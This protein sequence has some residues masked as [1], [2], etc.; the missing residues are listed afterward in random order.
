MSLF[1]AGTGRL[2]RSF[3]EYPSAYRQ[4][5][6][7]LGSVGF[8]RVIQEGNFIYLMYPHQSLIEQYDWE[9]TLRARFSLPEST[10]RDTQ[11][12]VSHQPLERLSRKELD[13]L[14]NDAYIGGF[15]KVL[16]Q[17][18]FYYSFYS[19]KSQKIYLCR[20]DTEQQAFSEVALPPMASFIYLFPQ[21]QAHRVS[22]LSTSSQ[23]DELFIYEIRLD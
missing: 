15:A 8:L 6:S 13:A 1:D 2:L 4:G 5:H 9:G 19:H 10:H 3:G 22:F 20:Y 23:S 16:G 18:V 21:A 17:P 14:K 11:F 12:K 7:F